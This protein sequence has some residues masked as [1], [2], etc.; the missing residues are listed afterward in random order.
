MALL[1]TRGRM[2]RNQSSTAARSDQRCAGRNAL[3]QQAWR[4][5][6]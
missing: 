2:H 6:S 1:V 3:R 4:A 5:L